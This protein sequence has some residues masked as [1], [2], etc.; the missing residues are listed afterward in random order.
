MVRDP[1]LLLSMILVPVLI[2]PLMGAAIGSTRE[3]AEKGVASSTVGFFS[4]DESDGNGTYSTALRAYL[5]LSNITCQNITAPDETKAVRKAVDSGATALVAVPVD[6]TENI[7]EF[8]SA[9]VDL[10]GI[11]RDYSMTETTVYTQV[12]AAL[13]AFNE[14]IVSQR[15]QQAYPNES[16]LNLTVPLVARDLSVIKG[17]P[18]AVNPNLVGGTILASSI[19][20]P[21]ALM[22]LLIMAGQLAATSVAME[23]E[24]KTLEVLL[25]LPV[26]RINI[27]IGK[28]SGVILVSML[29]TVAY[30]VG[31]TFY[32]NSLGVSSGNIDLGAYGLSPEPL[33]VA[34]LGVTLLLSFVSA[35][36]LAV[37]LSVFTKDVRSAQSLMGILYLP[38]MIPALVLMFA[39]VT[40]LP[41]GFQ[42]VI[43][44]IPFSY[45]IIASQALYTQQYLIVALGVAYQAIFTAGV[46]A[47]AARIFSTEKIMTA[48]LSFGKKRPGEERV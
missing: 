37:M 36:S 22:I 27:L 46:L 28:L 26:K 9:T 4:L 1:K 38:I 31:F 23:K 2:F 43:L 35:L 6:F 39:P 44:A 7:T 5:E 13:A 16:A 32:F 10:Y 18:A 47:V 19:A 14:L 33:G 34:L 42:A 21:M 8:R 20:M 24:Q 45:P 11:L 29:A 41:A 30:L 48:R 17:E 15:L 12:S 40:S 25:T 3:A